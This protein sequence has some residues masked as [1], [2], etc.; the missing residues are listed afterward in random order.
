MRTDDHR[1]ADTDRVI[2]QGSALGITLFQVSIHDNPCA[3]CAPYQGKVFST[4]GDPRFP[5]LTKTPPFCGCC[6][7]VLLPFVEVPGR[8]SKTEAISKFSL[9]PKATVRDL[10]SYAKLIKNVRRRKSSK[11]TQSI[12]P[13]EVKVSVSPSSP[14]GKPNSTSGCLASMSAVI[15]AFSLL[16]LCLLP[17]CP[18]C[19]PGPPSNLVEREQVLVGYWHGGAFDSERD[20]LFEAYLDIRN[21]GTFQLQAFDDGIAFEAAGTWRTGPSESWSGRIDFRVECSNLPEFP[22]SSLLRGGYIYS[23]IIYGFDEYLGFE[24]APAPGEIPEI[25][26]TDRAWSFSKVFEEAQ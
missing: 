9:D 6:R 15:F 21:D 19:L 16:A 17:G 25:G 4:N 22:G 2:Q 14:A 20:R 3:I 18:R 7:H 11:P 5:P 12:G 10:P 13:T 26:D 1:R 23:A 8:E 24:V